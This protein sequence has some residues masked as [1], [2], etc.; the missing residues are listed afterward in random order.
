MVCIY[1]TVAQQTMR[2]LGCRSLTSGQVAQGFCFYCWGKL[3]CIIE[4]LQNINIRSEQDHVLLS[5]SKW[6]LKE[7][8]QILH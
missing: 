4:I 8:P 5:T 7:I 1:P 2:Y 3:I 6:Q